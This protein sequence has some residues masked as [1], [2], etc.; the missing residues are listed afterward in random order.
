MLY[1]YHSQH[2]VSPI[3]LYSDNSWLVVSY[4]MLCMA[5][6]KNVKVTGSGWTLKDCPY[7]LPLDKRPKK[8][9][10]APAYVYP[11]ANAR[12]IINGDTGKIRAGSGDSSNINSTVSAFIVWMV[13]M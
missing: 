6:A 3:V 5:T 11:N 4:G 10:Q 2:S 12:I 8:E 9:L 1:V 13:G 7:I